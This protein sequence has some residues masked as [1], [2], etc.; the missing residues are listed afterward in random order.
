VK[1][2]N[3]RFGFTLAEVLITL[4]ILGVVA[5]VT[6]PNLAYNYRGKV[7][8]EQFRSTY[9]D[10]RQ[11]ASMLNYRY[12][13]WATYANGEGYHDWYN[14]FMSQFNGAGKYHGAQDNNNDGVLISK[15]KE[16]YKTQ[17]DT[18]WYRFS[19]KNG[20]IGVENFCDNGG[21]WIDSKGRIWTFNA[22][23]AIICVDVNGPSNPNRLNVDIF[24]FVPMSGAQAAV[25]LYDDPDHPNNYSGT[26]VPCNIEKML[27]DNSH[28]VKANDVMTID[29]NGKAHYQKG[30][31]SALDA[32]PYFAPVEN[33]AAGPESAKGRPMDNNSNYW[34][35][36]IEYK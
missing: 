14:I 11:A 24:A 9:S 13:D 34:Q 35:S 26:I 36:Y 28:N 33:S 1:Y 4:S 6:V 22:E 5:A 21:I 10:I 3:K 7:L 17:S 23:N 18:Y 12:G 8:E 2:F 16:L 25:W 32:C 20:R 27:D 29:A 30:S 15:M 31:G 19:I